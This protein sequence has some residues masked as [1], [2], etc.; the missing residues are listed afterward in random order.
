MDDER[1]ICSALAT[2]LRRQGHTVVTAGNGAL[3]WEHLHAQRYAVI[4]CDILMP[5]VD[6]QAFYALLQQYYPS[7]CARVLFLTDDSLGD[8]T[9]AFLEQSCRPWLYKPCGAAEVLHAIEQVLSAV[10]GSRTV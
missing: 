9:R 2:L 10:D 3:A 5:E 7:L 1:G 6:G 4:L 8:T